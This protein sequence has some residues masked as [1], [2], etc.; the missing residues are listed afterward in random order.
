MDYTYQN[1]MLAVEQM[2]KFLEEAGASATDKK[3]FKEIG[4]R[5]MRR[6]MEIDIEKFNLTGKSTIETKE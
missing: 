1:C 3:Q 6:F 4:T 2:R 5:A